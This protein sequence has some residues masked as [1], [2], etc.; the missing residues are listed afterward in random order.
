MVPQ[1]LTHQAYCTAPT[2]LCF[3]TKDLMSHVLELE[4]HVLRNTV[5]MGPEMRTFSAR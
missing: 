3:E 5:S 2:V 1:P 4:P